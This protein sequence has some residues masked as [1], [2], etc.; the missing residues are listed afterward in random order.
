MNEAIV[1]VGGYNSVWTAY[2]KI[3]R[4]LEDVTGLQ[5]IGVPL[6]PWHWW[7]ARRTQNAVHILQQVEETVV[8]ARRRFRADRFILVGHSAGG[9]LC[10]LYLHEGSVWGH[11]FAGVEHVTTLITLGSPHCSDRETELG[12]FLADEANRLTPGTPHTDRIRYLTVAG[13]WLQ[14]SQDGNYRQQRAYQ[15][16]RFFSGQ[17]D[18]WGDGVTPVESAGLNGAENLVLEGIAHSR[19][20]NRDW[21]GS[22]KAIIRRWWPKENGHG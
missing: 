2:L 7:Q 1:I 8:W 6:M 3:A 19:K 21:Y 10:R 12:W 15:A 9:I 17:G 16:Y 20:Y 22:S 13:R 18:V 4:D 5:G 14:G 11:T